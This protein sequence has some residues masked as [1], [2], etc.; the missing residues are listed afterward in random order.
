MEKKHT[1]K[2]K[3]DMRVLNLIIPGSHML[4]V[5]PR[6]AKKKLKKKIASDLVKIACDEALR[7][8]SFARLSDSHN[9]TGASND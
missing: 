5:L 3:L 8:E 2:I 7:T 4:E 6:K 9:L 1:I